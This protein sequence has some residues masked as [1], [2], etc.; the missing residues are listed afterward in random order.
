MVK[1][2]TDITFGNFIIRNVNK[3]ADESNFVWHR[4]KSDRIVIPIQGYGW[5]F[6]FDNELPQDVRLF[7]P[8]T[9]PKNSYHRIIKGNSNLKVFIIEK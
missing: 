6:Q 5:K 8:I 7:K 4:D 3:N 1:P 2:Y 9:I